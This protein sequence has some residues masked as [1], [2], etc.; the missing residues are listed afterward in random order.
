[1]ADLP[2]VPERIDKAAQP[3]PVLVGDRARLACARRDRRIE[4][5]LGILDT[6]RTLPVPPPIIPGLKRPKR[7]D[8]SDTQKLAPATES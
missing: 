4:Q 8:E 2:L 7:R 6:S 1:M 3:P 5:R